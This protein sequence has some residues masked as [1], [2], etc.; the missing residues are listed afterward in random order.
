M[1]RKGGAVE[2][3]EVCV[4]EAPLLR[5]DCGGGDGEGDGELREPRDRVE[6]AIAG[7]DEQGICFGPLVV[8]DK[9]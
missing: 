1:L 8:Q 7:D 6:L 9:R 4:L 3:D 2:A 5:S